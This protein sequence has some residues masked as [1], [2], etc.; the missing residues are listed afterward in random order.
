MKIALFGDVVGKPGRE[1]LRR[2]V[3]E[4]RSEEGV[5]LIVANVENM[6]HGFGITPDTIAE[7]EE[8]G[9][10]IF[11]S[12][13]HIWRNSRGVEMMHEDPKNILRPANMIGDDLP[14]RG[15]TCV[16][17]NGTRVCILNLLGEVFMADQVVSPFESF[18]TI[19][20]EVMKNS[21]VLVDLH[22]EATGE[23]R[24]FG[25]H[26]DGRA[27]VVVGTHTH[28][29]TAD[30]Q[31]LPGGTGYITDLG[32]CGATDSSLGMD[33]EL[34]HQKVAQGMDVSL[35]PPSDPKEVIASGL[36]VEV[37]DLSMRSTH[38]QR[39]DRRYSL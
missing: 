5:D 28:T 36:L 20:D 30:E 3:P 6:A 19:Y 18:D 23:K 12:G 7:L 39:I 1:A 17:V 37:D 16:D 22:A 14:G 21:V 38:V 9:V 4:M 25:W 8:I 31:I 15:V 26:V 33:R 11:T 13:N 10:D 35:E 34:V 27:T 2:A 32:F 24:I 29:Q